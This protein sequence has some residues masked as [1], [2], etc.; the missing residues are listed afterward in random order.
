MYHIQSTSSPVNDNHNTLY[1]NIH[2][3]RR[4]SATT[5]NVDM[6]YY[7]YARQDRKARSRTPITAKLVAKLLTRAGATRVLALHLTAAQI[8]GFFTLPVH[9]LVGAH[10]LADYF[11]RNT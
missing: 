1:I 11:L 8:Q 2:A 7:G 4:A 5:I 10:L 6:P 9:T 3:L